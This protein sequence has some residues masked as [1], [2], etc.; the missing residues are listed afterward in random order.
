MELKINEVF[1]SIQGEGKNMNVPTVFVRFQGCNLHPG[2]RWC[3]TSKARGDGGDDVSIYEV[4]SCINTTLEHH[5]EPRVHHVCITGGE[6]LVHHRD[7]ME[8]VLKLKAQGIYVEVFTN[9]SLEPPVWR[10][11]VDSWVADVKCPSS[12]VTSS[13]YEKWFGMRKQDQVKFV[14]ADN[15]DLEYV[16]SLNPYKYC[17]PEVVISPMIPVGFGIVGLEQYT[18]ARK[19]VDFCKLYGYRF[20]LQL[21]KLLWGEKEGV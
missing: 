13:E 18:W 10:Y 19:V 16:K 5:T 21:H 1:Y 4:M 7:V 15:T 11:Q 2:C 8:L 12:G 14:V 20:S 17:R 9:G 3:D 6:P